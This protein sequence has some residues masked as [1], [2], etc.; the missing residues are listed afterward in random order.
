PSLPNA[1][2]AGTPSSMPTP[3]L[4]SLAC[5]PSGATIAS[6]SSTG[7]RGRRSGRQQDPSAAPSCRWTRRSASLQRR[8]SSGRAHVF[9]RKKMRKV[10]LSKCVQR[11]GR[12]GGQR[13]G[14][15]TNLMH[16]RV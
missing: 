6:S 4:L 1:A 2:A 5:D 12:L 7:H 10:E 9:D 11:R 16:L 8:V 14:G 13:D 3:A 15:L